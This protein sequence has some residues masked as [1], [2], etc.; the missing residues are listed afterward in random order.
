MADMPLVRRGPWAFQLRTL[1]DDC[2]KII[3]EKSAQKKAATFERNKARKAASDE[4]MEALISIDAYEAIPIR[5]AVEKLATSRIA[6]PRAPLQWHQQYLLSSRL[7]GPLQIEKVKNRYR[8]N[9]L[10]VDA[11]DFGIWYPHIPEHWISFES[12]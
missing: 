7:R 2:W 9:K 12:L 11:M 5:Y 1:C 6:R 10:R 8:C 4:M 3:L